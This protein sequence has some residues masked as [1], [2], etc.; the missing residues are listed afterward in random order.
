MIRVLVVR[1][2]NIKNAVGGIA[3]ESYNAFDYL[4][5]CVREE[6]TADPNDGLRLKHTMRRKHGFKNL[7]Q[8]IQNAVKKMKLC[9]WQQS[10]IMKRLEIERNKNR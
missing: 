5:E 8:M 9:S 6:R 1:E 3:D 7:Y 4:I 2:R 10:D